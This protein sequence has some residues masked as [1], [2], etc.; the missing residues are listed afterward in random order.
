MSSGGGG[1][2]RK[3]IRRTAKKGE[4]GNITT[5]GRG[6]GQTLFES[7]QKRILV[8]RGGKRN[9]FGVTSPA[10]ISG[11]PLDTGKKRQLEKFE[12]ATG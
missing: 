10:I 7:Y 4:G 9:S 11:K 6:R 5:K 1:R 2:T 12:K 8:G 3:K